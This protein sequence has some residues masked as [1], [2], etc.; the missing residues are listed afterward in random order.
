MGLPDFLFD[1]H[2][3]YKAD[4]NRVAVWLAETAQKHGHTSMCQSAKSLPKDS[5]RPKGKAR[6]QEQNAAV[7]YK[8]TTQELLAMAQVIASQ[9]PPVKTPSFITTLL[10]SAIALRKRCSQSFSQQASNQAA[11]NETH[12]HFITVLEKVLSL[13]QPADQDDSSDQK[14]GAT[15]SS[16]QV[17]DSQNDTLNNIFD[18][19][20]I[21]EC[22]MAEIESTSAG[23]KNTTFAT[24]TANLRL[25]EVESDDEEVY[26]AMYCFFDDLN[27]L[28]EYLQI[29]W[30]DYR[31]GE[32][33]LVSASVTTN[34]AFQLVKQAEEELMATLPKLKSY[35]EISGVFYFLMCHLRG[36]DPE[37]RREHDDL[38]NPAMLDVAEWLYIPV[39]SALVSFCDVIRNNH[40]PILKH[41][42]LGIYDPKTDRTK[43]SPRQR[44][45]EDRIILMESF[46]EF[47]I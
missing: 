35:T 38:V 17:T 47:F 27:R 33:D 7:K 3:R 14:L 30:Q 21:E 37:Y 40:A 45:R 31:N 44:F 18:V 34:M 24:N 28:R 39:A 43:L 20:N 5:G 16:N 11:K 26:F 29:L 23:R 4:T 41:G 9:T 25:Y 1:S 2:K 8:V 32:G 6:N 42:H 46:P 22:E 13:L 12:S 15:T 36:Q 19:L 10:R